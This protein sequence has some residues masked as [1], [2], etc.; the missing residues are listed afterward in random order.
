MGFLGLVAIVGTLFIV[1]LATGEEELEAGEATE[2]DIGTLDELGLDEAEVDLED[3][4]SADDGSADDSSA[5][6]AAADVVED[7]A[8]TAPAVEPV[9]PA[10]DGSS[11]RTL[12]FTEAPPVCIDESA[13]YTA[14]L[15]TTFGE[16]VVDLD[17]ERAPITVNNFVFLA[18]YH[19]YDG[20]TF[21]RVISDFV[22][23]GG[24]PTG[25]PPG[26]GGPGYTIEEE[27]PE[28][29]EYQVG[30]L[31][32]A[33]RNEP[34]TTGAQFFIITGPDGAAL[35]PDF[36]LFGEVAELSLIHI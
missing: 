11:E 17:A 26:T 21:H 28:A 23:Q 24:D 2:T 12:S 32:M 19:Y 34:G 6:D 36:S 25:N 18:R 10:E 4:G 29:G 7:P 8:A 27:V 33:K 5:D 14:T 1:S 20:S 22:I 9:C 15:D 13:T 30:S 31:A 3:E 16:I 35:P